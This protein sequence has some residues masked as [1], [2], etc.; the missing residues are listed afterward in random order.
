MQNPSQQ[1]GHGIGRNM[2]AMWQHKQIRSQDPSTYINYNQNINQ[3]VIVQNPNQKQ[4]IISS[5]QQYSMQQQT[6]QAGMM[7]GQVRPQQQILTSPQQ[8]MIASPQQQQILASPG[9]QPVGQQQMMQRLPHMASPVATQMGQGS[10][11]VGGHMDQG[12]MVY[13][14]QGHGQMVMGNH[15]NQQA[16]QHQMQQQQLN[17]RQLNQN[18]QQQQQQ[19]PSDLESLMN[20]TGNE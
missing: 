18:F 9:Q 10:T 19:P 1:G 5:Q 3:R 12:Q 2:H 13:G 20:S 15:G 11:P 7:Q 16:G 14:Q 8:H 4:Q 17:S 6:N